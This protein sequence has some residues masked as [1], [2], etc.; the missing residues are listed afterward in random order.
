MKRRAQSPPTGARGCV[1]ALDD[2]TH[3]LLDVRAQPGAKRNGFAGWW[4]G[5]PKIA[6]SAAP[7]NGRANAA[8][9][10]EIAGLFGLRASAVSLESGATARVKTFRLACAAASVEAKLKE[11]ES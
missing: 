3:T 7:E 5:M 1:R 10:Q 4:N 6:V 11:L 8:I 9:A 2:G